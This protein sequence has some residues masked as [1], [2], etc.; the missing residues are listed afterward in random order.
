MNKIN[1]GM[2]IMNKINKF[3]HYCNFPRISFFKPFLKELVFVAVFI[4]EPNLFQTFQPQNDFFPLFVLQ[5]GISNVIFDL[6]LQLFKDAI[7]IFFRQDGAIP[8][9]YLKIVVE[10][11]SS[12]LC[13][14][15]SQ[16][17]FLKCSGFTLVILQAKIYTIVTFSLFFKALSRIRYHDVHSQSKCGCIRAVHSNLLDK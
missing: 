5:S 6:V 2:N 17:I 4:F 3:F 14:T 8:F 1:K 9:Q 12:T 16:L 15:G 10:V 11:H 13:S 7:K